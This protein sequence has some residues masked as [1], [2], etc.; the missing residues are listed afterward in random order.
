MLTPEQKAH[1]DTFGFLVFRQLFSQEEIAI[2]KRESVEIF[3]E[4]R[5]GEPFTGDAQEQIVPFFERRPFLSTLAD[6]DRIFASCPGQNLY[7]TDHVHRRLVRAGTTDA[8]YPG[9][10]ASSTRPGSPAPC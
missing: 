8:H 2:M 5:G 10:S 7:S 3:D 9:P 1:F 6:D 4:D